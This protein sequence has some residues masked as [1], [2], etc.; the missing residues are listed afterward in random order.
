MSQLQTSRSV[1]ARAAWWRR[2]GRRNL[3]YVAFVVLLVPFGM[4]LEASGPGGPDRGGGISAALM[5]WA[6]GSA[7]FFIVNVVLLVVALAK[8]RPPVKP[9]IGCA[10][11]IAIIVGTLM[12][13][14]IVVILAR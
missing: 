7:A 8:G 13:E 1:Q 11:P 14:D 6:I 3:A 2:F 5:M 4:V 10:L 9:L 12:S